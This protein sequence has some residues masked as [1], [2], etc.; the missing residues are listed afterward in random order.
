WEFTTS[1]AAKELDRN[2]ISV[3]INPEFCEIGKRRLAQTSPLN[4]FT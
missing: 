1:A 3:E 4:D 2:S